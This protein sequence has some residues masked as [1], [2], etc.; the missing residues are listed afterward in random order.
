[1]S[2]HNVDLIRRYVLRKLKDL[3]IYVS[4]LEPTELDA[5]RAMEGSKGQMLAAKIADYVLEQLGHEGPKLEVS[6]SRT[7][8]EA[9]KVIGKGPRVE[10]DS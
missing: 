3:R 10:V 4:M 9:R 7:V 2:V 5:L 1:M 6:D 8:R